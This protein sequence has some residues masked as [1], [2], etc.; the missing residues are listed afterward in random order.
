MFEKG[1][2]IKEFW[3]CFVP[4][5]VAV[6]AIG[7]LPLY[8][9]LTEGVDKPS[10]RKIIVQ[11]VITALAVGLAFLVFGRFV[12]RFLNISVA[13]F[14]IA[15]GVLLF[16]ISLKDLLSAEKG[17]HIVDHE[18]LGAVPLGVPL[19]VG[20]AVLTSILLLT[21]QHGIFPTIAA[22]VANVLIAGLVFLVSDHIYKFLG[23]VGAKIVSKVACLLLAS[24]AVMMIRKGIFIFIQYGGS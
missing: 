5:F 23:K 13:D 4:L 14:M 24:I 17:Q 10:L 18:S 11:S 3:I 9:N 8:M 21:D 12:L 7:V 16:V 20:P 1:T 6:D 19:I 15:G 22:T 2:M